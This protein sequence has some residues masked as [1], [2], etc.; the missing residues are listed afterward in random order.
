MLAVITNLAVEVSNHTIEQI[1]VQPNPVV[2]AAAQQDL[3]LEILRILRTIQHAY[4]SCGEAG[5]Q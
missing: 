4:A 5:I 2:N 1:N 3:Q